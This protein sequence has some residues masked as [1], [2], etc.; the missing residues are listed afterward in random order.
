MGEELFYIYESF[1]GMF[2]S[3]II[4][5]HFAHNIYAIGMAREATPKEIDKFRLVD[6]GLM[7]YAQFQKDY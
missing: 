5:G 4:T 2:P 7:T 6:K 1:S 3:D